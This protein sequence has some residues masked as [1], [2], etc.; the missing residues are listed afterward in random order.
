MAID[1]LYQL[2]KGRAKLRVLLAGI[3]L[4]CD[5]NLTSLNHNIQNCEAI[6]EVLESATTQFRDCHIKTLYGMEK[7]PI[8]TKN[9]FQGL[10]QLL[11]TTEV[12]DT[13]VLYFSGYSV[14]DPV[15]GQIYLCVGETDLNHLPETAIPL[16]RMLQDLTLATV[17]K[18]VVILDLCQRGG[19]SNG[20]EGTGEETLFA[21][22]SSQ[23]G[24]GSSFTLTLHRKIDQYINQ[25]LRQQK[26][27]CV[28]LFSGAG[29]PSNEMANQLDS[30]FSYHLIQALRGGAADDQG[31]IDADGLSAYLSE[32]IPAYLQ[33]RGISTGRSQTP[34][35]YVRG[36]QKIFLGLVDPPQIELA[37]FSRPQSILLRRF[38]QYRHAFINALEQHYPLSQVAYQSLKELADRLYL[39]E[40]E[41]QQ[42]ELEAEQQFDRERQQIDLEIEQRFKLNQQP[43]GTGIDQGFDQILET[44]QPLF[45]HH[46]N[47][48]SE[49]E[50]TRRKICLK[51]ADEKTNAE[52]HKAKD[53]GDSKNVQQQVC[54]EICDQDEQPV[55]EAVQSERLLNHRE[56]L[57]YKDHYEERHFSEED[58]RWLA[59][60]Q[61]TV[62]LPADVAADVINHQLALHQAAKAQVSPWG[63]GWTAGWVNQ[64]KQAIAD[65]THR[66]QSLSGQFPAR[67]FQL[68]KRKKVFALGLLSLA[69]I[70]ILA[71]LI[72]QQLVGSARIETALSTLEP[73]L[74]DMSRS[75]AW[76]LAKEYEQQKN[77]REALTFAIQGE[78]SPSPWIDRLLKQHFDAM[79]QRYQKTFD[80]N[81]IAQLRADTRIALTTLPANDPI[82]QQMESKATLYKEEWNRNKQYLAEAQALINRLKLSGAEAELQKIR[83]LG[84]AVPL[85][86]PFWN[87]KIQP[88]KDEIARTRMALRAPKPIA[89]SNR[90]SSSEPA[91]SPAA[92]SYQEPYSAPSYQEPYSAP[93]YQ[94][95]YSPPSYSA[96]PPAP[97]QSSD[98]PPPPSN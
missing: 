42:I 49:Q 43:I 26:S 24:L 47:G 52:S 37:N 33:E 34:I 16:Q 10:N 82:R 55:L 60:V 9:F 6:K 19:I 21:K 69:A 2:R 5:R 11:S 70:A 28:L 62:E 41:R 22:A 72:R 90:G 73:K 29:Q 98:P 53:V 12:K 75:T 95:P 56:H 71:T 94:E 86:S 97:A 45:N 15:S 4:Y 79:D 20:K 66:I 54:T 88:I 30:V 74:I 76:F 92:P 84:K 77:W 61:Q 59:K 27:F 44:D 8:T 18:Q 23:S 1:P 78:N 81:A 58:L 36:S 38:E 25:G 65:S 85:G 57:N 40:E 32:S 13:L 51:E 93:S 50:K 89:P 14:L 35:C 31:R 80:A 96:P 3:N 63:M 17:G 67:N 64:T 48:F 46:S 87:A 39:S 91:Y 7:S 83:L 68:S